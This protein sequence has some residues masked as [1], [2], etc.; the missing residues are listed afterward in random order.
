MQKVTVVIPNYNGIRFLADCLDA[1]LEQESGT[2]EYGILVVDNG[3]D[4]GS[5]E[6]LR[7]KYPAVK[8]QALPENTGFCHAV[9][10]GI[11]M[12]ET[13]YVILL[14]NDTRV[15]PGFVINLL[16]AI[17]QH[18]KAFSVSARM[19][20]WDRPELLDDAGDQY[21]VL[22][23]AYARGKGKPA[24]AYDRPCSVFSACAG[25][26]IYRKA[27]FEEIGY[28]DEE[29]FAYLED[30]DIGY[31]ARLFGY[32]NYYEP[33]AEVLHYGSAS[34]GSRYN[35]W[36]TG[37]AAANSVYVIGKNMPPLQWIWNLPFLIPGFLM[38]YLFFCRK[39][40]GK[41]YRQGLKKGIQ[42]LRSEEGKAR[43]I[44]FSRKR[45]GNYLAVQ[46]QL[47]RNLLRF[48][49]SNFALK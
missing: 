17:E 6:L 47:Y 9:N 3:S 35:E 39:G 23:W 27:V 37:L 45:L 20:M 49:N 32:E 30:L 13:P 8:V 41:T 7:E 38:K 15:R 19:L 44:A 28:F 4:D 31:R 22:G 25:A 5:A 12:A 36:K 43:K 42:K 11:R 24:D 10:V 48:L 29:H 18:E 21:C 34:S 1:L 2:P 16:R 46:G 14:N 33:S 40:L 26:A